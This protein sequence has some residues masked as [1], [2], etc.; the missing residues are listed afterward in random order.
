MQFMATPF[1]IILD[2]IK[3][4]FVYKDIPLTTRC[5]FVYYHDIIRLSF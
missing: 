2:E 4:V 3:F 5:T 1:W